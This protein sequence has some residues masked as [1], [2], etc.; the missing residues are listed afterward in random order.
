MAAH[1]A[2]APAR[3]CRLGAGPW[4]LPRRVRLTAWV[5]TMCRELSSPRNAANPV[6]RERS[7]SPISRH[8]PSGGFGLASPE[9]RL[10]SAMNNLPDENPAHTTPLAHTHARHPDRRRSGSRHFPAK[11]MP[12]GRHMSICPGRKTSSLKIPAAWFEND[13]IRRECTWPAKQSECAICALPSNITENMLVKIR[14]WMY[15][16]LIYILIF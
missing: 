14:I 12:S 3:T 9:A 8:P 4:P 16:S 11:N 15:I 7:S 6:P 13:F 5:K 1:D 10:A 2:S